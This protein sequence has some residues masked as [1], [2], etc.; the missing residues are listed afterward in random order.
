MRLVTRCD[1]DG[2]ACAMILKIC[3]IIEND[4]LFIHPKDIEE[5]R[6]HITENDILTGLP[7]CVAANLCFDYRNTG[8][9]TYTR[10]NFIFDLNQKSTA[11]VVYNYYK[12]LGYDLSK[13]T[14]DLLIAVDKYNSADFTEEEI[15]HPRNW[16]LLN[17][18]LDSKTGLNRFCDFEESNHDFVLELI[19]YCL[20]NNIDTVVK[21]PNLQDRINLYFSQSLNIKHQLNHIT[22]MYGDV[23][24]VDL[25]NE[26][27]IYAGNRFIVYAMFPQAKISIHISWDSKKEFLNIAI[28]KS[29]FDKSSS[30]NIGS[31]CEK[32]GGGGHNNAGTCQIG[33]ENADEII[34]AIIQD[35]NIAEQLDPDYAILEESIITDMFHLAKEALQTKRDNHSI[36]ENEYYRYLTRFNSYIHKYTNCSIDLSKI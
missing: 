14:E 29:I 31:I 20:T 11:R 33:S 18:I 21:L 27:I 4:I 28:G 1:F 2:L 6:V 34:S 9:N 15:L 23:A 8:F 10:K 35:C 13:I 36:S 25:R 12:N 17:F 22:K 32:Y 24:V 5:N 26:D 7:Y 3:N 19:D 30:V 16:I